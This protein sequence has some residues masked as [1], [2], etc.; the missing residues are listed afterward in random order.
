MKSFQEQLETRT[1]DLE[2]AREVSNQNL[3]KQSVLIE[4][5]EAL[6]E[7]SRAS[8]HELRQVT[9]QA[10]SAMEQASKAEAI[11]RTA[12]AD[13]QKASVQ[14]LRL[15]LHLDTANK[16]QEATMAELAEKESAASAASSQIQTLLNKVEAQRDQVKKERFASIVIAHDFST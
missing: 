2:T 6:R 11:S 14:L 12:T 1:R 8:G 7:A 15:Q 9:E 5:L 3:V 16:Q 13:S 10:R 4:Q